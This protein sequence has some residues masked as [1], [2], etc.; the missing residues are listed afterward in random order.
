[1][2]KSEIGPYSR[3]KGDEQFFS[4]LLAYLDFQEGATAQKAR[5]KTGIRSSVCSLICTFATAGGND[6]DL[7]K[8]E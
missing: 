4:V 5:R 7:R 2:K 3:A 8:Q 1:M 6:A